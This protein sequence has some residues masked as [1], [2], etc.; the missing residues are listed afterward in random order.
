[1]FFDCELLRV[2]NKTVDNDVFTKYRT[3]NFYMIVLQF[4]E[5]RITSDFVALNTNDTPLF[6]KLGLCIFFIITL[7]KIGRNFFVLKLMLG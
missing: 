7:A 4:E 5:N 1:M 3:Q 2:K 6:Y